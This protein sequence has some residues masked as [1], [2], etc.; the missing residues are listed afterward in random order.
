[1]RAC[2]AA[3]VPLESAGFLEDGVCQRVPIPDSHASARYSST[4]DDEAR[5]AFAQGAER[6]MK[7]HLIRTAI[8]IAASV[9]W[10][11]AMHASAGFFVFVAAVAAMIASFLTYSIVRARAAAAMPSPR[12]VNDQR[13]SHRRR[14]AIF[15]VGC[16]IVVAYTWVKSLPELRAHPNTIALVGLVAVTAFLAGGMVWWIRALRVVSR[17]QDK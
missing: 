7:Q 9:G 12:F 16:P 3:V 13:R 10:G 17:W 8:V 4:V 15:L 2:K 14:G 11:V 1:M 6:A 5:R